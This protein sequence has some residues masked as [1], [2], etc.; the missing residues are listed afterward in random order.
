M[1]ISN[2]YESTLSHYCAKCFC[3]IGFDERE[4]EYRN[5][6]DMK[7][8]FA[9]IKVDDWVEIKLRKGKI[10]QRMV[11]SVIDNPY[12]AHIDD[13]GCLYFDEN[14]VCWSSGNGPQSRPDVVIG[15]V[16][17]ILKPSEVI[18]DFGAFKGTIQHGNSDRYFWVKLSNLSKYNNTLFMHITQI[19]NPETRKLVETLLKQIK[20]KEC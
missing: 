4:K 18:V 2:L 8:K 5:Q 15:E 14:G 1:S 19:E 9:E 12:A 6:Y 17:R 16:A 11:C 7:P 10:V 3:E 13:R 20:G